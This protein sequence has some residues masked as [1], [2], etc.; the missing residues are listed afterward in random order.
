VTLLSLFKPTVKKQ[1]PT[2]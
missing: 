2:Y 1:N